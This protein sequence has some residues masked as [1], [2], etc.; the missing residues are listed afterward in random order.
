METPLDGRYALESWVVYTNILC[1]KILNTLEGL[2]RSCD[3]TLEFYL[4][5]PKVI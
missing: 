3:E 1:N 2:L 5:T 4:M